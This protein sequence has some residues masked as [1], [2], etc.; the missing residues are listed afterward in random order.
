[1]GCSKTKVL[2]DGTLL[3]EGLG[4]GSNRSGIFFVVY[5]VFRE[6]LKFEDLE[7]L[8]YC[9]P[10]RLD[11]MKAFIWHNMREYHRRITIVNDPEYRDIPPDLLDR[12]V[13]GARN[14]KNSL[15]ASH[16]CLRCQAMRGVLLVL[17]VLRKTWRIISGRG[18]Q[19]LNGLSEALSEVDAVLSPAFPHKPEVIASGVRRYTI[20]YDAIPYIFPDLFPDTKYGCSWNLDLLKSLNGD[21]VCFAISQQ[22]KDDFLYFSGLF[23]GK[24]NDLLAMFEERRGANPYTE[25]I[26]DAL[27]D[28]R[29]QGLLPKCEVSAYDTPL[30]AENIDVMLLAASETFHECKDHERILSVRRKYKIPDGKKYIFSLCTLERRKNILYGIRNF[31][32]FADEEQIGDLVFVLGGGSWKTFIDELEREISDIPGW[33]E[34]I[35][36]IGYVDDDDLSPL[37]SGAFCTVYPSIYEGFGL[38]PLE[39]MQCGCPVITGDNSSLPEVVGDAGIMVD[40]SRP[41]ALKQALKRLYDNPSEREKLIRRGLERAKRFSWEAAAQVVHSR[42]ARD[43]GSRGLRA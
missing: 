33:Q 5:N 24:G 43:C 2:Y 23:R 21:D 18:K 15:C 30:K 1:M 16:R 13:Q 12:A 40:V 38:P 22:T 31:L 25:H 17:K 29:R 4:R 10:A 26:V 37:F 9:D 27:R 8:L 32:K 42:I 35:L 19:S 41:D 34:R 6:L 7:I 14:T 39:A 20:L 28:R 36:R 3:A 11:E